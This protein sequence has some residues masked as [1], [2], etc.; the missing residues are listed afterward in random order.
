LNALLAFSQVAYQYDNLYRLEKV[1]YSNGITIDYEYDALGNRTKKTVVSSSIAVTGVSLDQTALTLTAGNTEQLTAT[2]SPA[3]ATNTGVTWSSSAPSVATVSSSGLV[4][5]V[6]AGTATITVTTNAGN[7]TA[8]CLVTVHPGPSLSVSPSALNFPANGGQQTVSITASVGWTVSSSATW[9]SVADLNGDG[10][11]NNLDVSGS[12]TL[13]IHV[14]A[15][16][17]TASRNAVVTFTGGGLTQTVSITQDAAT[18]AATL[19]VS[20]SALSFAA[21]GG[22]QTVSITSNV[23]W[24]ASSSAP[25]LTVSPSSGSNNGTFTVSASTHSGSS[26]RTATVTVS[27]TGVSS[28]TVA[29][30]QA[31]PE[32]PTTPTPTPPTPVLPTSVSLNTTALKLSPGETGQL[33][34]T[35]LPATATDRSVSWASNNSRVATVTT[36]GL[37]TAIA[38]GT[39]VI[40]VRTQSGGLTATCTVTVEAQHVV[41][42]PTP[43][44]NSQGSIEVSLNIPVNEPFSVSFTLTLPAGFRLDQ[45]ATTLVSELAGSHQLSVSPAGTQSWLFDIRPKPSLH[46]AGETVYQQV[47]HIV[48]TLDGTAPAGEHELTISNIDL[49][50]NNSNTTVHQDEIRIPVTL[51]DAT[52]TA[53]VEASQ[54]LYYKGL[55][56]VNTPVAEQIA[57]YSVAGQLLYRAQKTSGE[58]TFDLSSL[59]RGVLIIRGSSGWTKKTY[60]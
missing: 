55:L 29:V 47:V 57:V 41:A 17:S 40:T 15:H 39:A 60:K 25:W 28:R 30:T 54:V 32:S 7:Q 8:T 19:S 11:I 4:T 21:N 1:I 38:T 31:A 9:A 12:N 36:G 58:A 2:V 20:P 51:T 33:S 10:V 44:A 59:P 37:V 42:Q 14:T 45:S 50:L 18:P 27:G 26:A 23:H 35:V 6:S 46:S 48:Y 53:S 49:T 22:Q 24:T 43:P 13:T 5:A 56:T 3:N 34:A 16:T 52:G